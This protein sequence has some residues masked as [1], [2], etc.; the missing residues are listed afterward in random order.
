MSTS[1]SKLRIAHFADVQIGDSYGLGDDDRGGYNSR[2]DDYRST[3]VSLC[4]SIVNFEPPIDLVVMPG[5]LYEKA[6][7]SSTEIAFA[8]EGI[9]ILTSCL[10]VHMI[11]GNHDLH[12]Q[13]RRKN[14]LATLGRHNNLFVWNE[15]GVVPVNVQRSGRCVALA[16]FPYVVRNHVAANDPGFDKLT[17]DEQ[18]ERIVE[19]SLRVLHKLGAEADQYKYPFG[20]VLLAHGTISGSSSAKSDTRFFRD[21]ALPVSE[22]IGLPF[23]YQAWGHI[24][25][26]QVLYPGIAYSGS[27]ERG[28]FNDI[29][30]PKG[31]WLVTLDGENPDFDEMEFQEVETRPLVDIELQDVDKHRDYDAFRANLGETVKDA[32]VRVR[33]SATPEQ[34]KTIDDAAIKRELLAAGAVKVHGPI[35]ETIHTITERTNVVTE[36]ADMQTALQQYLVLQGLEEARLDRLT[37]KVRK[38][39]EVVNA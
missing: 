7:P 36:E 25:E 31:W 6:D 1:G 38:S 11:P 13:V 8:K 5:D 10:E 16:F 30:A 22:L 28:D 17:I 14:A 24:H 37:E 9:D 18:N 12:R 34:R 21:P 29:T 35:V 26:R 4:N 27:I 20:S 33:Y 39:M 19:L 2:L 32:I 3:F 23:R 15:P